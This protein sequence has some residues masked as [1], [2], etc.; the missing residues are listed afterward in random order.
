MGMRVVLRLAVLVALASLTPGP[1]ADAASPYEGQTIRIIVGYSPG[2]GFDTSARA[3]ARHMARYIPGNPS[4]VVENMPGAGS[5]IAANFTFNR[6]K[7]DGLTIGYFIGDLLQQEILGGQGV[8]FD[9]KKFEWMGAVSTTPICLTTK[10][11]GISSLDKWFAAKEPVKLAGGGP[12]DNSNVIANTLQAALGLPLRLV[13][14]HK[15]AA[16]MKLA[17][18]R[19]EVAGGCQSWE[20]TKVLW[21]EAVAAG[22][23]HVLLQAAPEKHPELPQVPLATELAKTDEARQLIKAAIQGPARITR[24][25]AIPPGTPKDRVAILRKAFL[26]TLKDAEFVA[27]AKKSKIDIDAVAGDEVEK[28]VGDLHAVPAALK[29]KLKELLLPKG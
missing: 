13:S 5:M 18:Q 4:F 16:D 9:S 12:G 3:L 7:P 25:F 14:G 22:D 17:A 23:I 6:A 1:P 27:D 15:G 20:T 8:A 28:V 24:L 19:G 11:S 2:G 10:A 29:P 21:Q 26:D